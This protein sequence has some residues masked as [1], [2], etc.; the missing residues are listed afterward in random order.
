MFGRSRSSR[1]AGYMGF[2]WIGD[3]DTRNYITLGIYAVDNIMTLTGNGYVGIGTTTPS[4]KF[5][6]AGSSY[7]SDPI[8]QGTVSIPNGNTSIDL[9][10]KFGSDLYVSGNGSAPNTP[11]IPGF[12][13]G[14]STS[15][16]NRHMDIVSGGDY[17]YIDF[18]KASIV[19]D[20][21]TRFIVNVSDGYTQ[22]TW[23]TAATNKTFNIQGVLKIMEKVSLNYVA[24]TDSLDF[25]FH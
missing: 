8:T 21:R 4:Y 12:Y 11:S 22:L 19:E 9:M 15:D 18:N 10:N 5:H 1:N 7:F 13:L 17:S 20:Y 25:I 24:S 2:N 23:N 16:E 6:V 3:N 14:K